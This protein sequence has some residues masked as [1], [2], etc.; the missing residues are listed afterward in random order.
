V[1]VK[2]LYQFK[3]ADMFTAL[4]NVDPNVGISVPRESI[5]ENIKTS[6]EE[7]TEGSL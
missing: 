5:R 4:L 3:I 7:V 6:A 1:E 2:K